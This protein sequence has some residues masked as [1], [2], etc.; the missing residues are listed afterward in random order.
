M[1]RDGR[2]GRVLVHVRRLLARWPNAARA[3][4]RA[5]LRAGILGA[6]PDALVSAARRGDNLLK[7]MIAKGLE[8]HGTDYEDFQDRPRR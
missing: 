1:G 2:I 7:A 4:V 8:A 3:A 6:R 5:S